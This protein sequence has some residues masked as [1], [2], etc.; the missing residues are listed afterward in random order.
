MKL[1][2]KPSEKIQR[3]YLLLS[4]S[5]KIIEEAILEYIGV[6]GWAKASPVFVQDKKDF[7]GIVLSIDRKALES[8]RAAFESSSRNINVKRV[9]GTLAGLKKKK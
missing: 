1:K 3:R 6:L 4:G 5:K 2:I 9:S 7:E 8:V